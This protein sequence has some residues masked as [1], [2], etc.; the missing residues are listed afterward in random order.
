MP[1]GWFNSRI[2]EKTS[3]N[4]RIITILAEISRRIS[5]NERF[6]AFL[7]ARN[8]LISSGVMLLGERVETMF[9]SLRV[10]KSRMNLMIIQKYN[11]KKHIFSIFVIV[12]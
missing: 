5:E 7:I 9:A 2:S 11:Q 1:V 3:I 10:M 6:L 8:S 12:Q 4:S